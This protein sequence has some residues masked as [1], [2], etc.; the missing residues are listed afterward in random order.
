MKIL[1]LCVTCDY[2]TILQYTSQC[3]RNQDLTEVMQWH[4]N[5]QKSTMTT[6]PGDIKS[7]EKRWKLS[8]GVK[9]SNAGTYMI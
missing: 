7:P 4:K 9:I 2:V 6:K 1:Y 3:K 5:L 8:F